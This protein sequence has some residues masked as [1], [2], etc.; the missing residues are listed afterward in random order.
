MLTPRLVTVPAWRTPPSR[1]TTLD[2]APRRGP[3]LATLS[4]LTRR[5]GYTWVSAGLQHSLE[6]GTHREGYASM[7]CG[8]NLHQRLLLTS[9]A[10]LRR[11]EA[12]TSYSPWRPQR[13]RATPFQPAAAAQ[14]CPSLSIPPF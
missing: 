5:C 13:A 12:R 9:L 1:C 10:L 11:A 6:K 8:S 4:L 2:G 14:C 7:K 3:D